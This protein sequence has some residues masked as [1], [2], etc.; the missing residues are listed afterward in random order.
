M[1]VISRLISIVWWSVLEFC[2]QVY[3]YYASW[4][5][6]NSDNAYHLWQ[7]MQCDYLVGWCDLF[8]QVLMLLRTEDCLCIAKV[9]R[10]Q[11]QHRQFFPNSRQV[12]ISSWSCT[13][14]QFYELGSYSRCLDYE[15]CYKYCHK[16]LVTV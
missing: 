9:S 14:N 5:V 2:D 6:I 3:I 8:S 15:S 1:T 7:L 16:I 13:D 10:S 11:I 12:Y 4:W